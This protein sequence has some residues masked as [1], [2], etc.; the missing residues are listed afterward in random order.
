MKFQTSIF[1]HFF[2]EIPRVV[3]ILHY[4]NHIKELKI[5]SNLILNE[6]QIKRRNIKTYYF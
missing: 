4:Q 3:N 2:Y 6:K 1:G 5:F